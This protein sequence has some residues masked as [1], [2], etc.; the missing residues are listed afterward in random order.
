[1]PCGSPAMLRDLKKM[2]ESR[3]FREGNTTKPGYFVME[4]AFAEQE[5]RASVHVREV[6]LTK[7]TTANDG[8]RQGEI[9]G[10]YAQRGDPIAGEP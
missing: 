9:D 1:M 5:V 2:L 10:S 4:R 7:R 8:N 3:G 6:Y